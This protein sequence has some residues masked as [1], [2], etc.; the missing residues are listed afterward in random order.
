[1]YFALLHWSITTTECADFL[2]LHSFIFR[3]VGLLACNVSFFASRPMMIGQFRIQMHSLS[4][5]QI[6]YTQCTHFFFF[7]CTMVVPQ[8]NLLYCQSGSFGGI[9]GK[10]SYFTP[11]EEWVMSKHTRALSLLSSPPALSLFLSQPSKQKYQ[12]VLLAQCRSSV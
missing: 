1:M 6:K 9:T 8:E 3:I 5:K 7:Q 12:M 11:A 10:N 2:V 4:K